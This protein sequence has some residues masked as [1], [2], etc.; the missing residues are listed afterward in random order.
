MRGQGKWQNRACAI[1]EIFIEDFFLG[2]TGAK[3]ILK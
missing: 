3:G 2:P 1:F